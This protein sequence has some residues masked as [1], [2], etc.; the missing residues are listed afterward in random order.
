[1]KRANGTASLPLLR[2]RRMDGL[3]R[4]ALRRQHQGWKL[5]SHEQ[6]LNLIAT[7]AADQEMTR[8]PCIGGIHGEAGKLHDA[9]EGQ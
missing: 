5:G 6:R 8:H 9:A 4:G 2:Q 7:A 3:K 1:V